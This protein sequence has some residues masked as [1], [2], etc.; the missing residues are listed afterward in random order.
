MLGC[1]IYTDRSVL[2]C[3]LEGSLVRSVAKA[4]RGRVVVVL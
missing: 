3:L 1:R 4:P 2:C